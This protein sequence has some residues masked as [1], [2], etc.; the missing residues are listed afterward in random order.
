MTWRFTYSSLLDLLPLLCFWALPMLL[1][2]QLAKN[3]EQRLVTNS[4]AS[5][6]EFSSMVLLESLIFAISKLSWLVQ[7]NYAFIFKSHN[8]ETH[9]T[10]KLHCTLVSSFALFQLHTLLYLQCMAKN[11]WTN[12]LELDS[13]ICTL[14]SILS[15]VSLP[16]IIFHSQ[17]LEELFS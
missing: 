11:W 2:N 12:Q 6:M 3:L 5:K 16:N 7:L 10:K 1:L 13:K 8:M 14:T 4:I 15:R 9:Q 17:W